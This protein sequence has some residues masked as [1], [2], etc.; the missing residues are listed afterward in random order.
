MQLIDCRGRKNEETCQLAA[1]EQQQ[2][3][4]KSLI[5]CRKKPSS[6]R[7][8]RVENH[9]ICQSIVEGKI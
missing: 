6:I 4:Q 8:E 3:Q 2:Q 5:K 7:H 9:K 1:R